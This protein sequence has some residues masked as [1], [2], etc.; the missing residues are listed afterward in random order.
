MSNHP[1]NIATGFLLS[2]ALAASVIHAQGMATSVA[3]DET[4]STRAVTS[5]VAGAQTFSVDS[6]YLIRDVLAELGDD[7][8][9]YTQHLVTLSN[10]F[11]EGRSADVSGCR[12]AADYLTYWFKDYG[13]EPAFEHD[14]EATYLQHFTVP[15]G[16]DVSK[17]VAS[18]RAGGGRTSLVEGEDFNVLGFSA[19]T[20]EPLTGPLSFVGYSIEE[21]EE[22][23][24]SYGEDDDL[25]G[26]IA[27]ILRFEPM[28]VEGQSVWSDGR[29]WSRHAGLVGKVQN[30]INRGAA[31]VILVN[32]PGADDPRTDELESA[33]TTRYGTMD[34]PVV[35]LSIDAADKLIRAADDEERTIYAFRRLADDPATAAPIHFDDAMVTI[36]AAVERRRLP[37]QNVGA[38][39]AGKGDLAGEWLV[40]GGHYDH[41][42]YGRLAGA[43]PSNVGKLHPGADDNAS[44][45][46]GVLLLSRNMARQYAELPEGASAR[47]VLFLQ[48]AAEEMGLLGARHF[49]ETMEMTS[50]DITGMLNL[51][52][53]GRVR[54]GAVEIDGMDSSEEIRDIMQ[55][56]FDASP[57]NESTTGGVGG[58]S[59]H[60]VFHRADI[61]AN[62]FF[63]GLHADYHR[64]GDTFEKVN[65]KGA[66]EVCRLIEAV[67]MDLAQR[68]ERLTFK[69]GDT[70]G[71]SRNRTGAR[72]RLGIAPGSYGE[73]DLAGVEIGDVYEGTSAADG[74]MK[75]GDR[76]IRWDGDEI[77]D[78]RAMMGKLM[79]AEPGDVAKIVVVRDG[80]EVELDVTLKA[81][82]DGDG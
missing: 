2:L 28:D 64:P 39:L 1:R 34:V 12:L 68:P 5:D 25:D 52:M 31:G 59:D 55:P 47:S 33:D 43:S 13:L 71:P 75:A 80:E 44:G 81:R 23:Y 16:M 15:G 69:E 54:E 38:V 67:A 58:S 19:N 53:I 82:E 65:F 10:P 30:A 6:E 57:L 41:V 22:G 76:I 29:R 18:Y 79:A 74:G 14:G 78:V 20:E 63:S 36:D 45:A 26:R 49:V 17:A 70:R 66:V 60:A 32:A 11:F 48:F 72:V 8:T 21:G 37:T 35:M 51:D 9:V 42:G 3:D 24:S 56:H 4:P 61:P 46:S 62:H 77:E 7:L 27:L 73:E 40:I 50:S